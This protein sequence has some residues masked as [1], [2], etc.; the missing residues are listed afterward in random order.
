ML[1]LCD[2]E[3][4]RFLCA[5]A[6]LDRPL[7]LKAR[8]QTFALARRFEAGMAALIANFSDEDSARRFGALAESL[9]AIALGDVPAKIWIRDRVQ[10][11]YLRDPL[12]DRGVG[13]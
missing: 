5:L 4:T 8:L 1:Q 3:E 6:A 11:P 9:G 2:G 7:G 12:L 13:I 10:A